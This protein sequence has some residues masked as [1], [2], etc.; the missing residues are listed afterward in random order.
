MAAAAA[1]VQ[2]RPPQALHPQC[3]HP[4]DNNAF[5]KTYQNK[6]K[7]QCCVLEL[8]W[9]WF[10]VAH[11][12]RDIPCVSTAIPGH[13]GEVGRSIAG[14]WRHLDRDCSNPGP[15]FR[16]PRSAALLGAAPPIGF[17]VDAR[18]SLV[19]VGLARCTCTALP[20]GAD[21]GCP[22]SHIAAC[23]KF[24]SPAPIAF[25]PQLAYRRSR[26]SPTV[27]PPAPCSLCL[28][29]PRSV[30]QQHPAG[31]KGPPAG[32]PAAPAVTCA[33]RRWRP[34]LLSRR[35]P[36]RQP[37][38]PSPCAAARSC[39]RRPRC[40]VQAVHSTWRLSSLRL[41]Q[42]ASCSSTGCRLPP[43]LSGNAPLCSPAF[44][45]IL[46]FPSL[47][48]L[49]GQSTQWNS[50]ILSLCPALTAP[51]KLPSLLN[52]GPVETIFAA[53]FRWVGGWVGEWRRRWWWSQWCWPGLCR[54]HCCPPPLPPA[55]ALRLLLRLLLL[56][57]LP[58]LALFCRK[59][60][61]VLYD[62]EVVHMPDGGCVALDTEDL[63]ASQ[64]G[65]PVWR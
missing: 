38:S 42:S 37:P 63:P 52:N 33:S 25:Y 8:L 61:H 21:A 47:L 12:H 2:V 22:A 32:A 36:P 5:L 54:Q 39:G 23:N 3:G 11:V 45:P 55:T 28:W 1:A 9:V 15:G 29:G 24:L 60:P 14:A 50:A 65:L 6:V 35:P 17:L 56:L 49:Q 44:S 62:R 31:F 30:R 34:L 19:C 48:R 10:L 64:V 26:P 57:W 27:C 41:P 58:P 13:L 20:A 59:K 4:T 46:S 51:Y 18:V 16:D 40:G 7:G 53:W 43:Q